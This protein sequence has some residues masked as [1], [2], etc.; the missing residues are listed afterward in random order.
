[1]TRDVTARRTQGKSSSLEPR[2]QRMMWWSAQWSGSSPLS[3]QK[4]GCTRVV[5]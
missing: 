2:G 1:M 3:K 5:S 4:R